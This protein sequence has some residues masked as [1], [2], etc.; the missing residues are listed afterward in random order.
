MHEH[1][2]PRPSLS[3][4]F[5]DKFDPT[6]SRDREAC[7]EARCTVTA[8]TITDDELCALRDE[9]IEAGDDGTRNIACGAL[10]AVDELQGFACRQACAAVL[11]ARRSG[12]P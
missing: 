10:N 7:T 1:R 12:R 5:P 2:N 4:P 11:N 8:E 3:R 9:A 6:A